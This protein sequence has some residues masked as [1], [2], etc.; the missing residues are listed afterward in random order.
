VPIWKKE[1]SEGGA[2]WIEG[3]NPESPSP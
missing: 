3:P 2:V 1:F